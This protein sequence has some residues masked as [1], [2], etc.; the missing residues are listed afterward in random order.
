M[1]AAS[2]PYVDNWPDNPWLGDRDMDA[3]PAAMGNYTYTV[4][5][6]GVH[7]VGFGK[8]GGIITSR[9]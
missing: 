1:D 7:L 9:D 6:T 8:A 5:G 2:A 3:R 4:T